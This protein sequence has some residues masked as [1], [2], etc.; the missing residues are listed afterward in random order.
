ME[1]AERLSPDEV[2]AL[3][4][5]TLLKREHAGPADPLRRLLDPDVTDTLWEYEGS[6]TDPLVPGQLHEKQVEALEATERHRFLFWGNQVGKSTIGAVDCALLALGRHP[7]QKWEPP[8]RIW[9][10]ALTWHLWETILLPELLTWIPDDRILDAPPPHQQSTKRAILVRADNG[11]TSRIEGKSAEQGRAKYQSARVHRIWFDEEHP[12]SIWDEAQPRLLR[13]GGDTITTMTPL[14]GLTWVYHRMYEPWKRSETR[15]V[16]CSHAGLVDNP[17]ISE[18]DIQELERQF[19]GNPAQLEARKHG[20]FT[21]PQGLALHYEPNRHRQSLT[22]GAVRHMVDEK[23]CPLYAGIDFGDWRF[24]FVLGL[25]DRA[26]RMQVVDELF[27]Q[28]EDLLSRARKIHELLQSYEAPRNTRIWGDAANAQDIREI[29]IRFSEIDS[30][31]RVLP[32]ERENKI[33]QASVTRLNT[34]LAKGALL[35]RRE[36][37]DGMQWRLG[38]SAAREGETVYGS[39]LMWE[40]ANWQY[41]KPTE[42]KGRVEAQPQDPDDNTADGADAIAAL[43]YMTMSWLTL[44]KAPYEMPEEEGGSPNRERGLERRMA[45]LNRDRR[46]RRSGRGI[47]R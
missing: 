7:N 15:E 18:E 16:F 33:R 9:A 35:F 21:R 39:R 30:P 20:H 41:P 43:R 45:Q 11:S 23:D 40:V 1:T 6:R 12:E 13:F 5:M 17:A 44:K 28:R 24:A 10:S 32:V 26:G 8:V 2:R 3:A 38:Q 36:L 4:R 46:R 37:G 34:L 42:R 29:N 27:S 14:L 25:Q 22:D 19:A 47:F 31:Y